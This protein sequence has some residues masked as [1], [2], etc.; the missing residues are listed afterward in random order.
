MMSRLKDIQLSPDDLIASV[1]ERLAEVPLPKKLKD[2]VGMVEK[3]SPQA[4]LWC[5][6]GRAIYARCPEQRCMH[7]RALDCVVRSSASELS[8]PPSITRTIY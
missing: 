8:F 5:L 2:V 1:L 3:E 4:R 7:V 6:K